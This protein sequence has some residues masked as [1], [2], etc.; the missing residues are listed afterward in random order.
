M[1]MKTQKTRFLTEAAL[2]AAL[3]VLLTYLSFWMGLDKG[4]VQLRLSEALAVLAAFTPAAIPGLFSGCMLASLLTGAHP[5]DIVFGSAA[6][7]F[8]ALVCYLLRRFRERRMLGCLL[9][10]LPNIISNCIVVPLLLVFVYG[11]TEAYPVILLSV[12]AGEILAGGV[13][14]ALLVM[15][16]RPHRLFR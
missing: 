14:G 13:L 8:G 10:P 6:T 9:L 2:I 12:A 7:L 1:S 5:L 16:L 3:Y 15:A 11:A 4:V